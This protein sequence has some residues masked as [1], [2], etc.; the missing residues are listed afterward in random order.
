MSVL[1]VL[2]TMAVNNLSG[3]VIAKYAKSLTRSICDV[4]RTVIIWIVGLVVTDTFG[5][6]NDI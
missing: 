5:Q 1:I 3:V 4:S 2:F 6:D